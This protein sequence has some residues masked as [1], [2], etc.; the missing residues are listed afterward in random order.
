[1]K[2]LLSYIQK[3]AV[4]ESENLDNLKDMDELQVCYDGDGG[5]G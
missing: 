3:M 4:A 5:G 2:D 1:V